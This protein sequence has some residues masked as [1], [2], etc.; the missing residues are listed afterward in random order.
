MI[1]VLLPLDPAERLP[2]HE[3]PLVQG[4]ELR[5]NQ[6]DF[7]LKHPHPHLP[8]PAALCCS[9]PPPPS[10]LSVPSLLPLPNSLTSQ[11]K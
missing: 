5:L 3:H 7:F 8:S 1:W 4:W 9:P 10:K 2:D 6:E 11:D